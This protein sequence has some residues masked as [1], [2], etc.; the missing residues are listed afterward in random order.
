MLKTQTKFRASDKYT[1]MMLDLI[2]SPYKGDIQYIETTGT[3]KSKNWCMK[4]LAITNSKK[5]MSQMK[6][7]T[8]KN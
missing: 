6:V 4:D 8:T 1:Y 2:H 7:N 3:G 5:A